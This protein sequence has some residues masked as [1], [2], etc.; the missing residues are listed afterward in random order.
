[1]RT[2]YESLFDIENNIDNIDYTV[3]S[4]GRLGVRYIIPRIFETKDITDDKSI[5][6]EFKKYA[7]EFDD[8]ID[9]KLFYKNVDILSYDWDKLNI[10]NESKNIIYIVAERCCKE[11]LYAQGNHIGMVDTY[12][13][14]W[15]KKTFNGTNHQFKYWRKSKTFSIYYS[16]KKG[17][18]IVRLT[19]VARDVNK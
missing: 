18:K 12:M 10:N 8:G 15:I 13:N 7:K 19:C 3:S 16:P 2:L 5:K 9:T 14:E 17:D 1:M 4:I 11:L 6:N